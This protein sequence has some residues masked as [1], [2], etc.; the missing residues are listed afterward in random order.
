MVVVT[1]DPAIA[2]SV[3]YAVARAAAGDAWDL[4]AAQTWSLPAG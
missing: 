4:T 2:V 1:A 3:A